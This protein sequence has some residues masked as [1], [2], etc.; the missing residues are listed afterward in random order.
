MYDLRF[1][2]YSLNLLIRYIATEYIQIIFAMMNFLQL[3]SLMN[4]WNILL[5]RIYIGK[6]LLMHHLAFRSMGFSV[7][8]GK[9]IEK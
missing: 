4:I 6:N 8:M 5:N 7:S 9:C 3:I 2:S 1:I